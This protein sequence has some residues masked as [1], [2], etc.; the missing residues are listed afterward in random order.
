MNRHPRVFLKTIL[1]LAAMTTT[2]PFVPAA[3]GAEA[4][5]MGIFPRRNAA[6]TMKLFKPMALYLE[7]HLGRQVKL[8]LS[9]D[10]AS[11]W[12]GVTERKYDIVH[13]N[14]YHYIKSK[15]EF[16]YEVIL[17]NEEFGNDTITGSIV[18]RT[19]SGI[20]TVADLKG[21]E[22]LFGGGPQA[23][24]SYIYAR[25]LLHQG[26]LKQ[27]DYI[28]KF[29]KNPPNAVVA[30]YY[31]KA[32]AAGTG[33]VVLNL[34]VVTQQIDRKKLKYLVRGKPYAHLVWAIRNDIDTETR[35]EVQRILSTLRDSEE[36]RAIL[37]A[38]KLTGLNIATDADYDPHRRIVKEVLGEEY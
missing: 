18:V 12:K 20:R 7:Q 1:M 10:F 4:L 33:D 15:K 28:E 21:K 14:Q 2:L 38:A 29:A 30:T 16:G 34:P 32:P 26:G 19:D 6:T 3:D 11:F 23:M 13:F 17:K 27:G 24:Q 9:K 31:K 35:N 22:V 5:T 25:Y 8:I 37:K 36:G